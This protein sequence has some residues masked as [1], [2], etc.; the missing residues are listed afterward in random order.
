MICNS[1]LKLFNGRDFLNSLKISLLKFFSWKN[2]NLNYAG[3]FLQ[4][5]MSI[6]FG[7]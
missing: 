2:V 6:F 4:T 1:S 7:V 5:N 3:V